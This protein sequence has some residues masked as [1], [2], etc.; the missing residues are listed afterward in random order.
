MVVPH[1][2]CCA[3]AGARAV[4]LEATR[5]LNFQ[6]PSSRTS[7]SS[8]RPACEMTAPLLAGDDERP[9]RP[10]GGGVTVHR[11]DEVRQQV[12]VLR[13]VGRRAH[14]LLHER[15]DACGSAR[16]RPEA[17]DPFAVLREQARIGGEITI[18]E[19]TAVVEQ[20]I[21]D[22]FL[23]LEL[24]QPRSKGCVSAD[25]T[26]GRQPER[27]HEKRKPTCSSQTIRPS[28]RV[29]PSFRTISDCGV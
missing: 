16:D 22:L 29:N 25:A 18:V 9:A 6:W 17:A 14:A 19:V 26:L 24:L 10:G 1:L 11:D 28:H 7:V 20:E 15:L 4:S 3:G 8:Y 12:I 2:V 23:V 13:A 27:D 21:L 5:R